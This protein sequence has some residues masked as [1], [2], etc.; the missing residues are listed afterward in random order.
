MGP[1]PWRGACARGRGVD[2]RGS[3]GVDAKGEATMCYMD[4]DYLMSEMFFTALPLT[5]T[6]IL[7][8]MGRF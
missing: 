4:A 3:S 1:L 7:H 8:A 2:G 6:H 5:H